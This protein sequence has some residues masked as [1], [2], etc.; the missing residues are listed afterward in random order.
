MSNS[1]NISSDI[2][3]EKLHAVGRKQLQPDAEQVVKQ[4]R[5]QASAT[6][7]LVWQEVKGKDGKTI[8]ELSQPDIVYL[9]SINS[10]LREERVEAPTQPPRSTDFRSRIIGVLKEKLAKLIG[11]SYSHNFFIAELAKLGAGAVVSLL[12][13]LGVDSDEISA[14]IQEAKQQ[15]IGAVDAG[16]RQLVSEKV[17][18]AV[19]TGARIV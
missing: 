16:L 18:F 9:S 19:I 12:A 10:A 4:G 7:G 14:I 8:T 15:K 2:A 6:T 1:F 17:L 13:R 11:D 3:K 5:Q